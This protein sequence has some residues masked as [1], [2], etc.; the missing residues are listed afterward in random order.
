MIGSRDGGD[1]HIMA[2]A[3]QD[4]RLRNSEQFRPSDLQLKNEDM[5]RLH[6]VHLDSS[7]PGRRLLSRGGT[8]NC[9]ASINKNLTSTEAMPSSAIASSPKLLLS[10][11]AKQLASNESPGVHHSPSSP[12]LGTK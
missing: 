3:D 1:N 5:P 8:V 4:D 12:Q 11:D 2:N 7:L 10:S 9:D 6:R